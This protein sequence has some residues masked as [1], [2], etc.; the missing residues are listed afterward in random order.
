[1]FATWRREPNGV[2]EALS[3]GEGPGSCVLSG[4]RSGERGQHREALD[5]RRRRAQRER[6][7]GHPTTRDQAA[8]VPAPASSRP[9]TPS[10]AFW[11]RPP[12]AATGPGGDVPEA[13]PPLLTCTWWR[14]PRW[15]WTWVLACERAFSELYG[16]TWARSTWRRCRRTGSPPG[17][18]GAGFAGALALRGA[19]LRRRRDVGDAPPCRSGPRVPRWPAQPPRQGS[20]PRPELPG[21]GV[22][23]LPY[24]PHEFGRPARDRLPASVGHR[25]PAFRAQRSMSRRRHTRPRP[26]S[27]MGTGKSASSA[28]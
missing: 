1:M 10:A 19:R 7:A 27:P 22:P 4:T 6:D 12:G 15:R 5:K 3:A 17:R 11:M 21:N 14:L 24:D 9:R 28:N 25:R 2:A 23:L 16:L 18:R 20:C 13:V 26:I 8:S